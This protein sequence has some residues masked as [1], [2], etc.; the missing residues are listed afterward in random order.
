MKH[1]E[2]PPDPMWDETKVRK[3]IERLFDWRGWMTSHTYR[4]RSPKGAWLTPADAGFPDIVALRPPSL[5]VLEVKSVGAS[6]AKDRRAVQWQWL[7]GFARVPG[8][9]AY[10][11]NSADWPALV[12]L[13]RDGCVPVRSVGDR[14]G[15]VCYRVGGLALFDPV[16]CKRNGCEGPHVDVFAERQETV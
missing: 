5:V 13:A 10:E 14:V 16:G 11:V 1:P 2:D 9:E 6:T 3:H 8:C 7:N 12:D 4:A 15:Q